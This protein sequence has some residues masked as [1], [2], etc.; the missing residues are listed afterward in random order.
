MILFLLAPIMGS[1]G[2]EVKDFVLHDNIKPPIS[3]ISTFT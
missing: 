3:I 2:I 1:I